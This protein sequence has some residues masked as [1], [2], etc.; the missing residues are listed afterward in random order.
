MSG[1]PRRRG[2]WPPTDRMRSS[3]RPPCRSALPRGPGFDL[4]GWLGSAGWSGP[5]RRLA[6]TRPGSL[7]GRRLP[8]RR[9]GWGRRSSQSAG[10]S[11]RRFGSPWEAHPQAIPWARAP[12]RW[13]RPGSTPDRRSPSTPA[14]TGAEGI[15]CGQRISSALP[16]S[17]FPNKLLEVGS[18]K[19]IVRPSN[20]QPLTSNLQSP[21]FPQATKT[22]LTNMVVKTPSKVANVMVTTRLKSVF[23]PHLP[24]IMNTGKQV[25]T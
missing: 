7:H 19:W 20:L 6:R 17:P 4:V 9:R 13:R 2:T 8:H 18:W 15:C 12:R 5:R 10:A 25:R 11:R 23:C 3:A 16:I 21:M 14:L 22:Q 1:W 24:N